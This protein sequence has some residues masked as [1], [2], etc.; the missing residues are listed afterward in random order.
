MTMNRSKRMSFSIGT[1]RRLG[2]YAGCPILNASC[3]FRMGK[4]KPHNPAASVFTAY[5]E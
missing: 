2:K 4:H 1:K 3:A 5:R